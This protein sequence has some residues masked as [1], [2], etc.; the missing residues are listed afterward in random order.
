MTEQPCYLI[1]R[2]ILN[3]LHFWSGRFAD[4]RGFTTKSEDALR[5]ARTEDANVV[6]AW[7]L[8][9]S[10]R[11]VEHLWVAPSPVSPKEPV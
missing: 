9:G 3:T 11:V 4:V 5:F 1:E 10:G 6:L 2:Y 8:D 7:L